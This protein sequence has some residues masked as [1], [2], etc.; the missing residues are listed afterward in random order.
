MSL[1]N[2]DFE[3]LQVL[4]TPNDNSITLTCSIE[5]KSDSLYLKSIQNALAYLN[6]INK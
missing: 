4:E 3:V 2:F 5:H 1:G 6:L